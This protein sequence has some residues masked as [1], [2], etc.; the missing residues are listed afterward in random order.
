ML[1]RL[2]E[3]AHRFPGDV[4]SEARAYADH[5]GRYR[6]FARGRMADDVRLAIRAK[7]AFSP[8]P[9]S[10]K[11]A[12]NNPDTPFHCVEETVRLLDY[13]TPTRFLVFESLRIS[14]S[15]LTDRRNRVEV[16]SLLTGNCGCIGLFIHR[17]VSCLGVCS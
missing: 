17:S 14:E 1:Y 9:P 7:S 11:V 4:L 12:P 16:G 10:S 8:G 15:L 5:A 6:S 3:H 13:T 2:E